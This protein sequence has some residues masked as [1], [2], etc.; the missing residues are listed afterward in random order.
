MDKNIEN[1][2]Y[3]NMVEYLRGNIEV[4][5]SL[6]QDCNSYNGSLEDFIWYEHDNYFYDDFFRDR[7]EVARA[8]YYGGDRYN[9]CDPYVRF[10]AYG[11][12]ETCCDY[13]REKDL[14]DNVEEILDTWLDLYKDNNVDCYDDKFIE[15][16]KKLE[17]DK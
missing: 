5:S 3:N 16:V 13:E 2:K 15:L 6:V 11:N 14:I 1:E 7:E 12:L 10:N 9:Y 17:G 4:L 8:V